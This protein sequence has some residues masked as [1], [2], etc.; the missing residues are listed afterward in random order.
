ML[1]V[2]SNNRVGCLFD[3]RLVRQVTFIEPQYQENCCRSLVPSLP[4]ILLVSSI[5]SRRTQFDPRRI[6][7]RIEAKRVQE[8]PEVN[9]LSPYATGPALISR[10]GRLERLTKRVPMLPSWN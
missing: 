9:K 5:K 1:L 3:D 10:S 6:S 4:W 7:I 8:T 2:V